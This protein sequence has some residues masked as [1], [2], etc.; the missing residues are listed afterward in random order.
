[1]KEAVFPEVGERYYEQTVRGLRVR[2]IPKPGFSK[3]YA[4]LAVDYGSIDT[5][6][7]L[8]GK[9]YTTPNGIAHYLEHKMFDMPYGDAMNR[10][11]EFGGSPNAFTSFSMTAYYMECTD[12]F[13]DNLKTLTEFVF[14]PYFT[15][16]SVDKEREIISQEIKM[17]EDSPGSRVYENL[18]RAMYRSHPVRVPIAGTVE[19]IREITPKM[20][21]DCHRAFYTPENAMLC[22]AG[23]LLPE[24]VF[25]IVDASMPD[26]SG[27][28]PVRNYG[29]IERQT[30]IRSY[31]ENQ[32]EIARPMFLAGFKGNAPMPGVDAMRREFI[33]DLAADLM[34]GASS[35]LYQSLYSEGLID[36]GFSAGYEGLKGVSLFSA[37]GDSNDPQAVLERIIHEAERVV[38]EGFDQKLFECL[39]KATYGR[40]V[41]MLDSF[42]LCCIYSCEYGFDGV[43]FFEFPSVLQAVTMED[44]Q[45]FVRDYVRPETASLSVIRPK[46]G[47][48]SK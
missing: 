38:R 7:S 9:A 46:E 39:K 25:A 42:E 24:E 29:G 43:E 5:H 8:D 30:D 16:K 45:A 32:M 41:R 1:M 27:A 18:F 23:D 48:D 19:S 31:S 20:L 34:L 28:V 26:V 13:A 47:G 11:A 10:F 12:H 6:F 4:F 35:P 36:S 22:I 14:T 3:T 2:V 44:V 15:Q 21:E 37:G 40:K 17:Y 33:G